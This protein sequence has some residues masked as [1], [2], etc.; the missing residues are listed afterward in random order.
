M[1]SWMRKW[2]RPDLSGSPFFS[3]PKAVWMD[4]GV[5][6][7]KIGDSGTGGKDKSPELSSVGFTIKSVANASQMSK[8]LPFSAETSSVMCDFCFLFPV[9]SWTV[10][11]MDAES[12]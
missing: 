4:W 3:N 7:E 1:G 11:H 10:F 12:E 6:Q 5:T 2:V 9:I 8:G